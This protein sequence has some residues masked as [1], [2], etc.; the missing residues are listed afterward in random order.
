MIGISISIIG[1]IMM[2]GCINVTLKEVE[3]S[4]DRLAEILESEDE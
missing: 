4:I 3:E 1:I 2:L